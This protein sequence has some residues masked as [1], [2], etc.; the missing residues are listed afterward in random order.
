MILQVDNKFQQV[1][2]KDLNDQNVG[3]FTSSVCEGKTFAEEQKIRELK[4]TISEHQYQ[5]PRN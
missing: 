3:T 2:I 4:I 5:M 1:N